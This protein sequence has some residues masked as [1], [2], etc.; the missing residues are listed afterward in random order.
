VRSTKPTKHAYWGEIE[1]N[2]LGVTPRRRFKVPGLGAVAV[3]LGDECLEDDPTPLPST[4]VL[5]TYA[6]TFQAFVAEAERHLETVAEQTFKRYV[7]LYAR[8][9]EDA[10][11]R[12]PLGL[13]TAEA[14]RKHL[15]KLQRLHVTDK[16]A[17]RLVFRYSLDTEH[18]LELKFVNGKFKAIGGIAET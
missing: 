15:G 8:Y 12:K 16:G 14:H 10:S 13:T 4:K 9:Y 1:S 7:R 6:K 5:D 3:L 11:A 17:V 18:G 2:L